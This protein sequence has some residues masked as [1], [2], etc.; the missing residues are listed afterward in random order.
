MA[1]NSV[2]NQPCASELERMQNQNNEITQLRKENEM[3]RETVDKLKVSI[4]VTFTI[5]NYPEFSFRCKISFVYIGS[6]MPPPKKVIPSL[7]I[8]FTVKDLFI[9]RL[10][11]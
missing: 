10:F 8:I 4:L 1:A 3:L 5:F 7:Q 11:F 9:K 6:E 2:N